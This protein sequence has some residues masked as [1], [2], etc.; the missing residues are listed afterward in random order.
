MALI[1]SFYSFVKACSRVGWKSSTGFLL[2]ECMC[3]F[4]LLGGLAITIAYYHGMNIQQQFDAGKRLK[5]LQVASDVLEHI[6]AVNTINIPRS[7]EIN[8][9]TITCTVKPCIPVHI[10]SDGYSAHPIGVIEVCAQ[11]L[12]LSGQNSSLTLIS[13]IELPQ[14]YKEIA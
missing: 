13:A 9:I 4:A 2:L 12:L 1:A 3:A 7:Q 8:G 11:W 14:N 5:A 10:Q 6:S